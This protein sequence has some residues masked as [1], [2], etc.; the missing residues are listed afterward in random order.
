VADVDRVEVYPAIGGGSCQSLSGVPRPLRQHTRRLVFD[1]YPCVP[2]LVPL[3]EC[4]C[5]F[6]VLTNGT[7]LHII[8]LS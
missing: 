5:H 7:K 3:A 2:P 4:Q 6:W 8:Q 1:L